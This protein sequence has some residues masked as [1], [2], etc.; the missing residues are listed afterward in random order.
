MGSFSDLNL[1]KSR[2]IRALHSGKLVDMI[3]NFCLAIFLSVF[4]I[5][6]LELFLTFKNFKICYLELIRNQIICSE[7]KLSKQEDSDELVFH[8]NQFKKMRLI[9]D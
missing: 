2:F 6:V 1:D 5:W 8:L 3:S 9:F 7:L 4:R